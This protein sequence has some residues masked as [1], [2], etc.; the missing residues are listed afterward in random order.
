MMNRKIM[1][2]VLF[3]FGLT[4]TTA[5]SKNIMPPEGLIVDQTVGENASNSGFANQIQD[6]KSSSSGSIPF[7]GSDEEASAFGKDARLSDLEFKTTSD[8]K[9]IHFKLDQYDLDDSS[10]EIL[11]KNA[12]FLK[13]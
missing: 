8:L 12:T 6:Q 3:L 10:R 2:A 11:N 1:I 4:L 13:N 5:C 7:S 9:D